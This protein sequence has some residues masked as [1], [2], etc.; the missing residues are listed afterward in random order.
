MQQDNTCKENDKCEASIRSVF[1]VKKSDGKIKQQNGWTWHFSPV[2]L[3]EW[4][5]KRRLKDVKLIN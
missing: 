3:Y 1:G 2:M 4:T 5:A